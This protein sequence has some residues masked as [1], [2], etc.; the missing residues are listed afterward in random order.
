MISTARSRIFLEKGSR[1]IG[2]TIPLLGEGANSHGLKPL[3]DASLAAQSSYSTLNH[4][5]RSSILLCRKRES[6]TFRRQGAARSS[7]GRGSA[8]FFARELNLLAVSG[9]S[10]EFA[11]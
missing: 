1:E 9:D 10:D 4:P 6:M 5:L 7:H 8:G 3:E 11:V 2:E